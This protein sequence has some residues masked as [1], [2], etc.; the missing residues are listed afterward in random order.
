MS[1]VAEIITE[2]GDW[3]FADYSSTRKVS[4]INN[5]Y[6]DVAGRE[7]WP[8]LE[9]EINLNFDGSSATPSNAPSDLSAVLKITNI[10]TGQRLTPCRLDDL[11]DNWSQQISQVGTPFV[12]YFLK[13]TLKTVPI[14]SAATA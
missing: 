7:P 10:A 11:E 6:W 14:S 13:D 1:T 2:M 8:F 3:G 5:A 4:A 12:Y 9:K